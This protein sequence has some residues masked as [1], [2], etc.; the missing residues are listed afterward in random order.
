MAAITFNPKAI[1][2]AGEDIYRRKYKTEWESKYLGDFVVIDVA[3]E[4]AFRGETPEAAYEAARKRS[5]KGPF[6]LIKIGE[7]GAFRVSYCSDGDL[8]RL[9][10]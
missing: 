8:D 5:A 10:R 7:A 2:E 3:G 6:H 9:F 4:Q 1:A